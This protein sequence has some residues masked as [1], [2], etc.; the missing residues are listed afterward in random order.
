MS[1]A[2]PMSEVPLSSEGGSLSSAGMPLGWTVQLPA[3][4]SLVQSHS[5][6]RVSSAWLFVVLGWAQQAP[7]NHDIL[8]LCRE[9]GLCVSWGTNEAP[10]HQDVRSFRR[11]G[12][13]LHILGWARTSRCPLSLMSYDSARAYCVRHKLGVP[14]AGSSSTLTPL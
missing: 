7:P 13:G 1:E 8:G 14:H 12:S 2:T 11:L 10:P 6:R 4:A 9:L 5:A 3:T